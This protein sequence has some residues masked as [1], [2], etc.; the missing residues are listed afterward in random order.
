MF[1]LP[2]F[3]LNVVLFPGMPLP[4]HIFEPR[5][6]LMIQRLLGDDSR[7]TVPRT[8]GVAL[9]IEGSEGDDDAFPASVGCTTE[10]IEHS[11][12]A[13]GRI[14]L[15]TEGR[16]RFRLLSMNR[17]DN[18]FVGNVEWLD[19]DWEPRDP[20]YDLSAQVSR[21]LRRYLQMVAPSAGKAL[22]EMDMP[23]DPEDFSHWVAMLMAASNGQKQRLLET[24]STSLRLR[25]ELRLLQRAQIVQQSFVR[26]TIIRPET[27]E[28]SG[29]EFILFN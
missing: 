3:P 12:L 24:T 20:L 4:L 5:Y 14:N 19:D 13:D 28:S 26:R 9:L 11:Y 16:R 17:E 1:E 25:A 15:Q 6:R 2:I 23:R 22:D 8:F 7:F 18:Y 29:E 21:A 27:E 10:I